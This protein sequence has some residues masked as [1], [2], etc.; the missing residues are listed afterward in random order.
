MSPH[1]L[2]STEVSFTATREFESVAISEQSLSIVVSVAAPASQQDSE[3]AP[4]SIS[5]VLDRSGSMSGNKIDLLKRSTDF[6]VAELSDEDY[7]GV[8]SY[9]SEV[10]VDIPLTSVNE[11]DKS[12]FTDSI[13]AIVA[14]GTTNLAGGLYE[15]IDQ[16]VEGDISETA[17]KTVILFTDG[18]ANVGDTSIST[19]TTTM[20]TR[21]SGE[22][23]PTVYALG[24]G[25]DHDADF[26][27]AIAEAG[28]GV[29]AFVSNNNAIATT[30]GE[31]LGGLVTVGAQNI[32]LTFDP[33]NN[34][35]I[36][37]VQGG[38]VSNN[39]TTTTF[40]DLFAEERRDILIDLSL[41]VLQ[42]EV[43]QQFILEVTLE[44]FNTLTGTD[45]SETI[46]ISVDRTLEPVNDPPAAL[47]EITRLRYRVANDIAEAVEL[48]DQG[49]T[50]G[51]LEILDATLAALAASSKASS[52]EV[53]DF[54]TDVE[55]ARESIAEDNFTQAESNRLNAG[56]SGLSS[57]RGVG[58]AGVGF[59]SASA[60]SAQT[61]TAFR[62]SS[63]VN[64]P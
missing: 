8:V 63:A 9:S 37:E 21:L 33:K 47:V 28:N 30:I 23:P 14:G 58:T 57:Q 64:N 2:D 51:A 5:C 62:A 10:T 61:A 13:D 46:A 24:F 19:I 22:R 41:P 60:T 39:L 20:S 11:D 32:K 45:E 18:L 6:L 54:L 25:G 55:N 44:Y 52:P 26:L 31:I 49:D 27:E 53:Q 17:V 43:D 56:A 48:R 16:Q 35:E 50:D 34:V 1:A 12:E 7:F 38:T 42:A 59:A 29:Y 15:G 4:V 36:V 40:S 3:R